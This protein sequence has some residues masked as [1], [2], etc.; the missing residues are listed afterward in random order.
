[1]GIKER[2][3]IMTNETTRNVSYYNPVD[4]FVCDKCNISLV[5]WMRAEYDEELDD[6]SYYEYEFRYCPHCGR[7]V[8]DEW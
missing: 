6:I 2:I 8:V 4:G 3:K 7:K 1:M 5:D